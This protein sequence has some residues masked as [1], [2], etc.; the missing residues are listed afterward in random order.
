M[1]IE[2]AKTLHQNYQINTTNR[3]IVGNTPTRA[4]RLV[5]S[6]HVDGTL[7]G[8]QSSKV[9]AFRGMKDIINYKDKRYI[10][11]KMIKIYNEKNV[12]YFKSK[13]HHD[14]V[15]KRLGKY[16]FLDEITEVN[17]I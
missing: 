12:D 13:I 15:L 14:L 5:S 2:S 6:Y 3:V 4:K 7:N 1:R 17:E 9:R 8:S 11:K 10:V 16:Y